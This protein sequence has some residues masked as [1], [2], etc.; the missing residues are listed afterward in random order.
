MKYILSLLLLTFAIAS[1]SV[2]AQQEE[3]LWEGNESLW[4]DQDYDLFETDNWGEDDYGIFDEDF[5][6]ETED[7]EQFDQ[8]YENAEND[9]ENYDDAGDAGLFDV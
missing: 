1:G 2:Y 5:Y 7:Q 3:D 4:G 9:W 8:W 6:W